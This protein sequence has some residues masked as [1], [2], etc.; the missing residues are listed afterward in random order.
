[1]TNKQ[2]KVP[3]EKG[4]RLLGKWDYIVCALLTVLTGLGGHTLLEGLGGIE[5]GVGRFIGILVIWALL[6]MAFLWVKRKAA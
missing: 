5:Y 4:P 2:V 1:M 3:E 6:K